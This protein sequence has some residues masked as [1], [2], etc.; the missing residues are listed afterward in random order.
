MKKTLVSISFLFL[1]MITF[2]LSA[3]SK[4]SSRNCM[5][6]YRVTDVDTDE[7]VDKIVVG[8]S[9][10]LYVIYTVGDENDKDYSFTSYINA[11][12]NLLVT[13]KSGPSASCTING[14]L[15]EVKSADSGKKSELTFIYKIDA[16]SKGESYLR[17]KDVKNISFVPNELKLVVEG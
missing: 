12:D 14:N 6:S 9:Y 8:R 16:M 7:G 17:F 10:Y 11:N 15:L 5:V 2:G 1:L 13:Y 3:C 4:E